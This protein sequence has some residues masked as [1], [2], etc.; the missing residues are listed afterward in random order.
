[1]TVFE[2]DVIRDIDDVIDRSETREFQPQLHPARRRLYLQVGDNTGKVARAEFRVHHR[3]LRVVFGI[4]F[5]DDRRY[6]RLLHP[7]AE[8]ARRFPRK[9]DD[10]LAVG[11]VGRQL[12][13]ED[14][15]IETESFGDGLPV[16]MSFVQN[17][18]A[19]AARAFVLHIG[20]ADLRSAAEH[21]GGIHAAHLRRMDLHAVGKDRTIQR[22]GY[23]AAFTDIRCIGDDRQ[24]LFFADIDFAYSETLR[25]RMLFDL[26]DRADINTGRLDLGDDLRNFEAAQQHPVC[27]ILGCCVEFNK[28]L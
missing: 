6:L 24:R 12:N 5:A 18:N 20:D 17:E 22:D 14:A 16:F 15:V 23:L 21:A 25:V 11:A 3:D 4:A 27:E 8:S 9:A 19:V 7:L 2:K 13:I 28:I 1:M 26:F 10:A